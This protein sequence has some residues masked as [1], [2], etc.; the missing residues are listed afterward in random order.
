MMKNEGNTIKGNKGKQN[1]LQDNIIC[2]ALCDLV[3]FVQ[4]KKCEKHP[5]KCV[6]FGKVAG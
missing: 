1:S 6:A 2:D 3:P 4:F 5:W